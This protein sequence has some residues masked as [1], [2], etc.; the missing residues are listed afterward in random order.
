MC[1]QRSSNIRNVGPYIINGQWA[2]RGAWP[3]HVMLRLDGRFQCGGSLISDRW[4]LTAA[5]CVA[6]VFFFSLTNLQLFCLQSD[7]VFFQHLGVCLLTT[8]TLLQHGD[9]CQVDVTSRAT[10]F[11]CDDINT[12]H[13][14]SLPG[15]PCLAYLT[16]AHF[17]SQ[18]CRLI[19]CVWCNA[20]CGH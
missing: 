17:Q 9:T 5:H 15:G 3:W 12:T 2:A 1:G 8:T 16:S 13:D 20:L 6:Y 14:S 19:F 7:E 4:V 18:F 10:T 11:F